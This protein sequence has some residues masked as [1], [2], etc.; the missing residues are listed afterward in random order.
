MQKTIRSSKGF[1]TV[2][3]LLVL[4]SFVMPGIASSQDPPAENLKVIPDGMEFTVVTI[5]EISSKTA[6]EGDPLTFK[7]AQ[8]VKVDGQVVIAK[9]SLVKGIV[10]QAKK[11]GMMGRGGSLGIRVESAMTVD[12]Q[13][14]KLRSTKGKEGDDKTGTTVAL[15]VLFGPLGFLK[16]G[17]NAVIKPGTE[18]KVYVDEEKK[19]AIKS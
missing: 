1:Q 18:I 9:D 19:V 2:V 10:A 14:L 8:D 11:A 4:V 15:V 7:V 17:K 3:M 5:D 16:K 13:K 6:A 12:N